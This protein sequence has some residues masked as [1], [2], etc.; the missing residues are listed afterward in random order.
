MEH[1]LVVP[2]EGT[3]MATAMNF[4][5]GRML[6][7]SMEDFIAKQSTLN[8]QARRHMV[9]PTCHH[10]MNGICVGRYLYRRMLRF[11]S[12][13]HLSTLFRRS[14][15]NLDRAIV[16]YRM[17]EHDGWHVEAVRVNQGE[18]ILTRGG[19]QILPHTGGLTIAQ[20]ICRN[21]SGERYHLSLYSFKRI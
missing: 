2:G 17:T 6:F 1:S 4:Y 16:H 9:D 10:L 19:G 21:R 13:V 11:S 18:L 5:F 7:I 14:Y 15:C 12:T 3:C 8:C 20:Y